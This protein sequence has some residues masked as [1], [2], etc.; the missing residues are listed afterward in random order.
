MRAS[1]WKENQDNFTFY[2]LKVTITLWQEW[3]CP[4]PPPQDVWQ[5]PEDISVSSQQC[6]E[7]CYCYLDYL[8]TYLDNFLL[9]CSKS[10]FSRGRE[11]EVDCPMNFYHKWK[12]Y[13]VKHQYFRCIVF[14]FIIIKYV[15]LCHSRPFG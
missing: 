3:L 11:N 14:V 6:R 2:L 15:L 1:F 9:G 10:C 13:V 5:C 12:S 7:V 4:T 8:Q